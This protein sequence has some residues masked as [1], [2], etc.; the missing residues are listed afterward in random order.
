MTAPESSEG[1]RVPLLRQREIEARIVGPL[2]Q[3]VRDE[4]GEEKTLQIARAVIA[5]LARQSG[6][7][8]AR[9]F[10]EATLVTFARSLDRW[11]EG[12]ALEIEMLEQS[13]QRLAFNVVRCRYA[14]MYRA[15][16]L[17][18]LGATLSCTRDFAL[19]EGFNPEIELT[20]TQTIMQG[21]THCDFR[22]AGPGAAAEPA[23]GE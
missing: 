23:K 19:V 20:R 21:A 3:A 5:E 7:E 1:P 9:T 16:G 8:L 10:G 6:A 17:A 18:D 12:G 22:F 13:P 2:L 15:L 4:L 11:S 14:E